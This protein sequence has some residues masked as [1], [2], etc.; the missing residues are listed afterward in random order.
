MRIGSI[1][2]KIYTPRK[3]IVELYPVGK[4]FTKKWSVLV[5]DPAVSCCFKHL[6]GPTEDASRK[7]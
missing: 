5:V 3:A 4:G 7:V 6:T 1:R 2:E